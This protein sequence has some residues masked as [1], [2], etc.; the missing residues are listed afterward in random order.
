VEGVW[1][2]GAGAVTGGLEMG[3]QPLAAGVSF[4]FVALLFVACWSSL[5]LLRLFL[6]CC[7]SQPAGRACLFFV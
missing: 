5:V 2:S 6:F 7:R 4:G 3:L 1:G